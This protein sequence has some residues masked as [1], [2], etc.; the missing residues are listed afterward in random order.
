M[1]GVRTQ[2]GACGPGKQGLSGHSESIAFA[3]GPGGPQTSGA[4]QFPSMDAHLITD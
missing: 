1:P 4:R 2:A 3:R